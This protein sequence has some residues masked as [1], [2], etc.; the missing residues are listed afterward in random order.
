[1]ATAKVSR[2]MPARKP[3]SPR[4]HQFALEL[5]ANKL[6]DLPDTFRWDVIDSLKVIEHAR[7]L[8]PRPAKRVQR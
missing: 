8:A 4:A 7:I 5:Y 1:M 6:A 3:P 2:R